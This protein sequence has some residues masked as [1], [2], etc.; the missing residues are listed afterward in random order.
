M[1]DDI[2]AQLVG[3]FCIGITSLV[4]GVFLGGLWTDERV[5]DE[6]T[7]STTIFCVEKPKDCKIKYDYFKIEN[8]K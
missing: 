6:T 5:I 8:Q 1:K 7:K 4:F 2:F 3:Y